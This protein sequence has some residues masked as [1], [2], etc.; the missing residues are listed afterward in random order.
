M[1]VRLNYGRQ[2]LLL[3]LPDDWEIDVVRKKAMPILDDP[4]GS[5]R[6]ALQ[7]PVGSGGLA[8]EARGKKNVCILICDITRP[9]PNGL[10]LPV[11]VKDLLGGRRGQ[12]RHP[13][14]G[15]HRPAPPQPGRGTKGSGGRRL[16]L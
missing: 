7:N 4:I 2:G 15:G 3:N 8:A 1:Q 14:P 12:R 10:I 16:G 9:V 11:L 6:D 13:D 5:A